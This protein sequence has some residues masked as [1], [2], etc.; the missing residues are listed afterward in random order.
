LGQ[1]IVKVTPIFS[2]ELPKMLP[3]FALFLFDYR[4]VTFITP[5]TPIFFVFFFFI[6]LG[7]YTISVTNDTGSRL[8]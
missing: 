8:N 2:M 4:V 6:F 3:F 5:V 1:K 7:G